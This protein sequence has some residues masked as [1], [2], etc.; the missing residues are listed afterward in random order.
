MWATSHS[1]DKA[2]TPR[3]KAYLY[4][5]ALVFTAMRTLSFFILILTLGSSALPQ[6]SCSRFST[7][8]GGN[9]TDEVKGICY[10]AN[11]NA[12]IIGSTY[13]ADLPVTP[14]LLSDTLVGGHDAFVARLDSCGALVW[15]TYFGTTAYDS[16]EK[17]AFSPVD[18]TVV[19]TGFSAASGLPT[20]AGSFQQ[21]NNGGYDAF[22]CK[23]DLTGHSVWCT[24]FGKS[25][26]DLSYDLAIDNTGHIAM[27]GTST[28][29][30]LY[31][32]SSSF[33]QAF[34]GSTDAYI[35]RF[36]R[37]GQMQWC[38]YY[39][40]NGTEDIHVLCTDEDGNII[41]AGGSFS[42]N[43][44]TSAGAFQAMYEGGSD[45]YVIKLDSSGGRLF[46]TYIGGSAA[47]DAFGI[48]TDGS[49]NIYLAGHTESADFDTTANCYQSVY[50]GNSDLYALKLDHLG[51]MVWS[52][53]F[54]GN[55]SDECIRM[56]A[57]GQEIYVL[58]RTGSTNLP[59]I[60]APVQAAN[61][62]LTDNFLVGFD[63][64][65]GWPV[66]SS[67]LGGSQDEFAFDFAMDNSKKYCMAGS[68][69]ST[70]FPV[71]AGCFQPALDNS[72]DGFLYQ[73]RIP[74]EIVTSTKELQKD[75]LSVYP[76]PASEQ[77]YI[78]SPALI[79]SIELITMAG[80]TLYYTEPH[81]MKTMIPIAQLQEGLYV[82]AINTKGGIS[83]QKFI[84]R[85]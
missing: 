13:S 9:S 15:C 43:L 82:I 58:A 75:F 8:F 42:N 62:G 39:G 33:Q 83:R 22:L 52:T 65:S 47:D 16:G 50:T 25:G 1:S 59:M 10:D 7:F 38:T 81:A 5:Y 78:S 30:N 71:T 53:L 11:G 41:G 80:E 55:Q 84:V 2:N 77:V 70:D 12:Y 61:A 3:T 21:T 17:I 29:T 40:G 34:N 74:S 37:Q 28:S 51:N 20:N 36:S 32:T 35:A 23:I 19:I 27:G 31:T 73:N 14:G 72:V 45:I 49:N 56:K 6:T 67:Y 85:R 64:V 69:N 44:N 26:S 60:D 66:W 18:Q 48:C 68:T 46:S 57:S 54:G 76:N 63:M 4:R 24:Y 79:K